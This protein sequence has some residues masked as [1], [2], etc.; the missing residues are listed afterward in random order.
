MISPR[1]QNEFR[2]EPSDSGINC[3]HMEAALHILTK[4]DFEP[5][6]PELVLVTPELRAHACEHLHTRVEHSEVE[7]TRVEPSAAVASFVGADTQDSALKRLAG[8]VE[9]TGHVP[10]LLIILVWAVL[11]VARVAVVLGVPLVVLIV[12][13]TLLSS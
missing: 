7:H 12:L 5:L 3:K 8:T 6:S 1:S 4:E 13:L 9:V 10:V 11:T 2:E